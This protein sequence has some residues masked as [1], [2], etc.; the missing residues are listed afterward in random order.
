MSEKDKN[1]LDLADKS[2]AAQSV[3]KIALIGDGI[4]G[5]VLALA[6]FV[7]VLKS[8][9]TMTS[10]LIVLLFSLAP[11]IAAAMIYIRDKGSKWIR[12]ITAV[13]F[14]CLYGY[15]LF[16]TVSE[17]VFCY[18][19][20]FYVLMVIYMD[21]KLLVAL[22]VYALLMNVLKILMTAVAAGLS[23]AEITNAEIKIACLALTIVY[24]MLVI[25][26]VAAINNANVVKADEGRQNSEKLLS[27]T[28]EVA[29]NLTENIEAAVSETDALRYAIDNTQ[30]D[31][32]L[33]SRET[34]EAAAA[35]GE[36]KNSTDSINGYVQS[37]GGAVEEI[38][39]DIVRAEDSLNTG[40][41]VM[42]ELLHQVQVSETSGEQVTG[43]MSVLKDYADKMQNIMALIQNVAD[44]TGLLALNASIEAARAGDAGRGFA[45]VATEISNL[46]AQTKDATENISTLIENVVRSV[47][48]VNVSMVQLLESNRM[49]NQYVEGTA[50]NLDVIYECTEGISKEIAQLKKTV[51]VVTEANTQVAE[52]AEHIADVMQQ[53]EEGANETLGSCNTNLNSIAKVTE[54]M[55]DIKKLACQLNFS[56]EA[57]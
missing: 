27:A 30:K 56:A 26:K 2:K 36:Q 35:I 57:E 7:E 3:N 9:R 33:L 46:S 22:G 44:Q 10:Y 18:I 39:A 37:V 43:E 23:A 11:V 4:L 41:E 50:A 24:T 49:Q 14:A 42:K 12:Y 34:E 25:R 52:S 31:M 45:V 16:N 5:V 15:L 8:A 6:Y 21:F 20:V 40:S 28:M 19:I 47:D 54:I 13:G 29:R 53:V 38:S 32:S 17:L 1:G 55:E 51:E 48:N